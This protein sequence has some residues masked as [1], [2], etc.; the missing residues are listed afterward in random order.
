M[1]N[2]KLYVTGACGALYDGVSPNGTS[3][4]PPDIQQVHQAYGQAYQL[5]NMSAH[6]ETC[7]NIG[8]VLWNFRML[9]ITGEAKYADMME[10]TLYNSVLSGTDLG[11][12]LFNYTNPLRVDDSLPYTLRWSKE[13]EPYIAWSNC[14]P[15]NVVRTISEV[16]NYAYSLTQN[17]VMV[18]LYGS[19]TLETTLAN[20]SEIVLSQETDY[21]WKGEVEIRI[22]K[23]SGQPFEIGL[24]IPA[25]AQTAQ[26][27]VNGRLQEGTAPAGQ[28]TTLQRKW[29]KGD[30]IEL[31]LP[32]EVQL[33]GVQSTGGGN[34]QS[35]CCE[36]GSSGVLHRIARSAGQADF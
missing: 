34:P 35:S 18:N 9:Q 32:M 14:C 36:T 19:N 24:R 28:Y 17:G 1:A 16:N 27:S 5:P 31:T 11:G 2:R 13:R 22:D 4:D 25:W 8:N 15:P 33:S 12:T 20:G 3:Y 21:P 6:N 30:L 23:T 7:A 26:I 29:E 10:L